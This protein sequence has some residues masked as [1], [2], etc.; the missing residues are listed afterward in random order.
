MTYREL[1]VE[2]SKMTEK[3]QQLDVTVVLQ[4]YDGSIERCSGSL[5]TWSKDEELDDDHPVI[6]VNLIEE[7]NYGV[8]S[9]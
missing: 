4:E 3:Q 5:E 2:I 7:I 1:A 6:F 9:L 8:F